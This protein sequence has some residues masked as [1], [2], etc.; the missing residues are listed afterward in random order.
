MILAVKWIAAAAIQQRFW[1]TLMSRFG[2]P[3]SPI[4]AGVAADDVN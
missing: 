4:S 2:K 3:A 1:V